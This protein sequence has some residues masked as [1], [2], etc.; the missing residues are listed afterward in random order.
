M[1]MGGQVGATFPSA[2]VTILADSDDEPSLYFGELDYIVDESSGYVEVRVWRT[3]TDLSK[4]ATVTVRSRKSD[5]VS[6]E[7]QKKNVNVR[8][9]IPILFVV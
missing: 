2:K 1:P 3:G 9:I 5:P 4:T 7:G 8:S 6:A